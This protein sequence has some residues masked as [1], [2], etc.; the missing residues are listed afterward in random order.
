MIL[1]LTISPDENEDIRRLKINVLKEY[2][3]MIT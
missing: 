3:K 1:Y 2:D